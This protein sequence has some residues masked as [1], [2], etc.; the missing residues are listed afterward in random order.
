M[1]LNAQTL[2]N[3]KAFA[4][5]LRSIKTKIE[6]GAFDVDGTGDSLRSIIGMVVQTFGTEIYEAARPK[7]TTAQGEKAQVVALLGSVVD[8]ID[9]LNSIQQATVDTFAGLGISGI[10]WV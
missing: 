4:N 6:G 5:K 7:I 3:S 1:E 9:Q 10:K 8:Q 2:A